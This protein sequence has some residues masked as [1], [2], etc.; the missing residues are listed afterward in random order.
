MG[1]RVGN[2]NDL[3]EIIATNCSC[4]MMLEYNK[5]KIEEEY[6]LINYIVN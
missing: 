3:S 1:A 5:T 6:D 4:C 2:M